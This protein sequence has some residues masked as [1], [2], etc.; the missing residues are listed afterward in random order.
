[1]STPSSDGQSVSTSSFTTI[2]IPQPVRKISLTIQNSSLLF[3][4]T[5]TFQSNFNEGTLNEIEEDFSLLRAKSENTFSSDELMQIL[6]TP[7]T[8]KFNYINKDN[9]RRGIVR[10][11]NPIYKSFDVID[12]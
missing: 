3:S 12:D 4:K 8:H 7:R 10:P 1:M 2:A 5:P 9:Q 6:S 11:K